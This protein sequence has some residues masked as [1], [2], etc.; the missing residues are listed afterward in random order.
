MISAKKNC[1]WIHWNLLERE[2]CVEYDKGGRT[3]PSL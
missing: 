3:E 1:T 2:I